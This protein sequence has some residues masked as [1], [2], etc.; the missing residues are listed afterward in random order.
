MGIN[1]EEFFHFNRK[2]IKLT[3]S[4]KKPNYVNRS[5]LLHWESIFDAACP[6]LIFLL[7]T[8]ENW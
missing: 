8:V 5:S 6:R 2:E 1:F 7:Q 3:D 4:R